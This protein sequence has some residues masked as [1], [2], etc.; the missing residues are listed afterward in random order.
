MRPRNFPLYPPPE[1]VDAAKGAATAVGQRVY[2]DTVNPDAGDGNPGDVWIKVDSGRF[3]LKEADDATW[4][5]VGTVAVLASPVFTGIPTAPTAAPGTD[6]TQLATTEFVTDAVGTHTYG[7]TGI[8]DDAVTYA[9]MQ[10][11]S[12]ASRLLG[13][14]SA[15]GAGDPEEITLGSGLSMSGTTLS[16][17]GGSGGVS[18]GKAYAV[19]RGF[20]IQ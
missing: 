16:A 5:I 13:R 1:W 7:T 18:A 4:T 17:T 8:D 2:L 11:V 3:L 14:G 15:G 6:T 12:A 20:F 9:K 10:N 19:A